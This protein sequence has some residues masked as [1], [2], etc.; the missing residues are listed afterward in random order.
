MTVSN[1]AKQR[2]MEL[3]GAKV[4]AKP[5]AA[6]RV[7]LTG[8][9]NLHQQAVNP[10]VV[11]TARCVEGSGCV[12]RAEIAGFCEM[13][14]ARRQAR[15]WAA[16]AQLCRDTLRCPKQCPCEYIPPPKLTV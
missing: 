11:V 10:M 12:K 5:T 7:L 6:M 15:V 9:G 4:P 8:L 1:T 14:F 2:W 16:A 3:S 13:E